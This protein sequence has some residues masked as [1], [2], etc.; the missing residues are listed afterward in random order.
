M[1]IGK[2]FSELNKAEY[3]HYIDNHKQYSDFNTLGLYRSILENER[4]TVKDQIEIRDF[5]NEHFGKTFEFLQL[6]DP[7]VYFELTT[8]G[9]EM[10][11]AD[12]EQVWKD[13]RYNQEQILKSKRISHRNFGDYSKHNCGHPFCYLD[14]IMIK[15]GS[16]LAERCMLFK[17]DK[18]KQEAR[19]KSKRHR[20]ER[21]NQ[22]SIIRNE[23]DNHE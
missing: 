21:K 23:M 13:I 16:H 2:Q 5:A 4:F 15:Q 10:T 11:Q 9:K 18:N 19:Q 20:K 6:K 12:E 17:S 1:K 7:H 3:Q 8:L 14:G 22:S